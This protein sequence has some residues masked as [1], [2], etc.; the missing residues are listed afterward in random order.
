[1][2]AQSSDKLKRLVVGSTGASV[3]I[4]VFATAC[5][6]TTAVPV[7]AETSVA[8][9]AQSSPTTSAQTA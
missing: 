5:L 1:M 4:A 2:F 3:G 7:R 6:F 8:Q 9:L